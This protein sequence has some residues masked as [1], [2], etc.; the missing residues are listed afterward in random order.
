MKDPVVRLTIIEVEPSE[1]Q[2]HIRVGALGTRREAVDWSTPSNSAQHGTLKNLLNVI[3][4]WFMWPPAAGYAQL[5]ACTNRLNSLA[6]A[7]VKFC[8]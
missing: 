5:L 7:A 8:G 4:Q 3:L 2:K 1:Y 6:K